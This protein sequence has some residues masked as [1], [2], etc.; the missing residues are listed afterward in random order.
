MLKKIVKFLW[1][2][3]PFLVLG[4]AVFYTLMGDLNKALIC[5][6]WFDVVVIRAKLEK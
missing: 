4:I 5:F 3:Q 2:T 6:V 1:D